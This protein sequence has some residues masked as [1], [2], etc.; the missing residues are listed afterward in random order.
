[1]AGGTKAVEGSRGF[2][3]PAPFDN[4]PNLRMNVPQYPDFVL[5]WRE[6][7]ARV[8]CDHGGSKIDMEL[9]DRALLET[10]G[11]GLRL[12]VIR[13]LLRDAIR[14]SAPPPT[15]IRAGP[16]GLELL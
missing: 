10:M 6:G 3:E 5:C 14:R 15:E 9:T 7:K 11:C 8:L 4:R 1:M 13:D 16:A 2:A 12:D